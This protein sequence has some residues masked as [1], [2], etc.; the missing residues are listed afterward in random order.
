M[1]DTVFGGRVIALDL[2]AESEE[3]VKF[4]Y[5]QHECVLCVSPRSTS[6]GGVC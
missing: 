1:K 6:E 4:A 2:N 3:A 5:H